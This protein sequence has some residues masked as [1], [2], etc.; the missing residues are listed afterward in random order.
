MGST[1]INFNS[2]NTAG[3]ASGKSRATAA[4]FGSVRCRRQKPIP[5]RTPN[6]RNATQSPIT[7]NTPGTKATVD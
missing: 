7:G 1:P 2:H 5:W 4:R 3:T 6:H